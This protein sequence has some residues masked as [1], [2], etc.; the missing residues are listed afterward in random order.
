MPLAVDRD[1]V[2]YHFNGQIYEGNADWMV[3]DRICDICEN[4]VNKT[5]VKETTWRIINK[6]KHHPV[7][8]NKDPFAFPALDGIVDL[9]TG[10][11]RP[12]TRN[13]DFTYRYNAAYLCDEANY[14]RF[15]WFLMLIFRRS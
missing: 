2:L 14:Q 12:Y 8:F 3:E 6:L 7:E 5:A 15:L 9:K 13:E 1:G 11:F 4:S 10:K